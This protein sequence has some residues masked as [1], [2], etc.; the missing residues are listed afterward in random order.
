MIVALYGIPGLSYAELTYMLTEL[1]IGFVTK[2]GSGPVKQIGSPRKDHV[3]PVVFQ[4]AKDVV[5]SK[6]KIKFRSVVFV[7]DTFTR[8]HK[9]LKWPVVGL[10]VSKNGTPEY[11]KFDR[12]DLG[13]LL[14]QA[15]KL[16]QP[17]TVSSEFVAYNPTNEMLEKFKDSALAMSHTLMH[18]I[19][20]QTVRSE[21]FEFVRM[22]FMGKVSVDWVMAQVARI[23]LTEFYSS[24]LHT[25]LT[26]VDGKKLRRVVTAS[27]Q[28]PEQLEAF[29]KKDGISP[30]D[31]RY[32][33]SKDKKKDTKKTVKV[34]VKT[35]SSR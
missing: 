28:K 22:Y 7:T 10:T 30:F 14:Q 32:L 24:Q 33:L 23:G 16:S 17:I 11:T 12:T 20:D 26:S 9:E 18:K 2:T 4:S 3:V 31:V 15:D 1:G 5:D 34:K 29:A 21:T 13:N 35:K 25:I 19:K 8:L 27:I 6:D